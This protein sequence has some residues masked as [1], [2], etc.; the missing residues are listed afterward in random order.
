MKGA[1]YGITGG[2][3]YHPASGEYLVI[4]IAISKDGKILDCFTLY[5]AETK[6]IG[7]A[8]ASESFYGQ[9]DGKTE[10]S[11]REIDAISGAT[12]T[13]NG[14][15]KA[16][17]NSYKAFNIFKTSASYNADNEIEIDNVTKE[18]ATNE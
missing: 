14:Y 1:G 5:Q 6:G 11:Y 10:E 2:D 13:T 4:R 17:E 15:L 7:D 9:F 16:I 3:E 12:L 18:D 8:C